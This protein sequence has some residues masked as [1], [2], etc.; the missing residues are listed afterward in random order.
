MLIPTTVLTGS[1]SGAYALIQ[2]LDL[3]SGQSFTSIP[4]T[5][6]ALILNVLGRGSTAA[7]TVAFDIRFNSDSGANYDTNLINVTNN[8][9]A[10]AATGALSSITVGVV[11]GSTAT[12]GRPGYAHIE[13]PAYAG[14]TF[15]KIVNMQNQAIVAAAATDY[16]SQY[17]GGLW[18]S[19]S[20]ITQIDIVISS[21]A[22]AS[23][24]RAQLYGVT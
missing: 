1:S 18:R 21:G 9:A 6:S 22:W 13:I 8:T 15:H 12:T 10:S 20:A 23:G 14:T 5:Y 24:S 16:I 7:L 17:R 4:G 19:T 3:T 2:D 11:A